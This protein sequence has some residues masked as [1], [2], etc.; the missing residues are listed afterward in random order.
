MGSPSLFYNNSIK[1]NHLFLKFLCKDEFETLHDPEVANLSRF[2]KWYLATY[3]ILFLLLGGMIIT[4]SLTH[5]L[6][7]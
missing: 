6:P 2:M 7:N 5:P 1:N 4:V 3:L